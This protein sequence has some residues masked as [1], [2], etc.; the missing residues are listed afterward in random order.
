MNA[1]KKLSLVRIMRNFKEFMRFSVTS[2]ILLHVLME[3]MRDNKDVNMNIND[4]E[5]KM[6]NFTGIPI[7][8]YDFWGFWRLGYGERND[9]KDKL[10]KEL[11]ASRP[12]LQYGGVWSICA[13]L[14]DV[15]PV[16]WHKLLE[17]GDKHV[18]QEV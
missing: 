16:N 17:G 1:P 14:R 9:M 2:G 4:L 7:F 18:H 6:I 8:P 12:Y 3:E 5:R 13:I 11:S 15:L 10:N